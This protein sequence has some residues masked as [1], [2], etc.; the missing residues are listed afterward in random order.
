MNIKQ[1]KLLIKDLPDDREVRVV[2][3]LHHPAPN[4]VISH[5]AEGVVDDSRFFAIVANGSGLYPIKRGN[6]PSPL[7]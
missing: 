3:V 4:Y 5:K 1:L 7:E 2:D 6:L